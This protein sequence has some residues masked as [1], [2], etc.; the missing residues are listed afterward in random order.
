M[1]QN[2]KVYKIDLL[3]VAVSSICAAII[4]FGLYES[5]L[6]WL[7]L[8]KYQPSNH[9]LFPATG[10]FYNPGPYCGFLAV[11][12]P[13]A[14]SFVINRHPKPVQILS[15]A[16][17]IIALSLM[18]SLMGRTGW[19]AAFA[20]GLFILIV[21]RKI[22]ISIKQIPVIVVLGLVAVIL[23]IYMKPESAFGRL[24]L[25][26]IGMWAACINPLTGSGL[27][28]VAG[29]IGMAQESYFRMNPGSLFVNVAGS[30]EYPFNEYLTIA[31]AY[32]I[33]AMMLFILLLVFCFWKDFKVKSYGLCGSILS[34]GVVCLS[35]Y[36]LQFIEF[37]IVLALLVIA[38][39]ITHR[40]LHLSIKISVILS[41]LVIST[42]HCGIL[43]NRNA[44]DSKWFQ[45]R[46]TYR[47]KL[48]ENEI[49]L[50][51]S[52]RIGLGS[53]PKFLFDYGRMLRLS[54][55]YCKSNDILSCG[56]KYS[57]DPMYLILIGRNYQD[58][59]KYND[60]VFW[61]ERA[62][63]RHPGRFYP[64]YLLAKLYASP[65]YFKPEE[66]LRVADFLL[67]TNPKIDSPAIRQMKVEIRSLSDSIHKLPN[68]EGI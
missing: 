31:I 41:V 9:A 4:I 61:Y 39:L 19:I 56:I 38:S 32:G 68:V 63:N 16:Y 21:Y 54:G 58:S 23:L 67:Q 17:I 7:Q 62:I 10:T 8:L 12:V 52:M 26:I 51:D 37:W 13:L 30:P 25:W 15:V 1:G 2:S 50:L 6:G 14:T 44:S 24:F 45:Y 36:P 66:F 64:Y 65:E 48:T 11:I 27:N 29:Q 43:L 60:A 42:Y 47:N 53:N 40:Q 28:R 49:E 55:E 18:P 34:F 46:Y 59:G 5:V 3:S 33:P 57:S 35:S 22:H 20:G